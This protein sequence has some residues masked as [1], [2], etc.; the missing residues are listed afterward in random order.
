MQKSRNFVSISGITN[1]FQ[2]RNIALFKSQEKIPS[3]V[4]V[5][6]QVS[7]KSINQGIQNPRQ[8]AFSELVDLASYA[9]REGIVSSFHYYTKD[10]ET[11]ISDLEKLAKSGV[12]KFYPLLQ[13]NTLPPSV[14]ILKK[15]KELGFKTIL[16]VNVSNKKTGG[17]AVWKQED[18]QDASSGNVDVLLNQVMERYKFIHYVM[19]DPSHGTNL[20]L[21]FS[22]NSLAVRFGK[23]IKED[24]ELNSLGLVYAGGIGPDNVG[25]VARTLN[26]YFPDGVSI[27]IESK[28]R[29]S[30]DKL[31]SNLVREYLINCGN[32]LK[33]DKK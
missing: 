2:V 27:D 14:D 32:A 26:S 31:D 20:P 23:G 12:T 29:T 4:T 1:C 28:V 5:G 15:T 18:T 3:L 25:Q 6:Y 17:Y 19:F 33:N 13:F 21:D 30:D 16:K 7:N 8:P 9:Y 24:P 10:N 22:E 11:I